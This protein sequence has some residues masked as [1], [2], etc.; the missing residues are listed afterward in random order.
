MSNEANRG[1]LRRRVGALAGLA[2]D[3]TLPSR[4]AARRDALHT[5]TGVDQPTDTPSGEQLNGREYADWF[6]SPVMVL[7]ETPQVIDSFVDNNLKKK[8]DGAKQ[9]LFGGYADAVRTE[10]GYEPVI[11][12]GKGSITGA[13]L[14][15]IVPGK[16]KENT[17]DYGVVLNPVYIG[18]PTDRAREIM[19]EIKRVED[20]RRENNQIPLFLDV[21]AR[22]ELLHGLRD[23]LPQVVFPYLQTV[24]GKALDDV[25][26]SDQAKNN[27]VNVVFVDDETEEIAN[28]P[29]HWQQAWG[30]FEMGKYG[31][32]KSV[33]VRYRETDDG[34]EYA[35]PMLH[36]LE[37]GHIALSPEDMV[38]QLGVYGSALE[39]GGSD[40]R[41]DIPEIP[42]DAWENSAGVKGLKRLGKFLGKHRLI[43][44]GIEVDDLVS[45][46]D[47]SNRLL[48][49][50]SKVRER[51][52]IARDLRKKAAG[53]ANQQEG[54][55]EVF[56]PELM[57]YLVSVT[58]KWGA[59]KT[60]L[61]SNDIVA[62][63]PNPADPTRVFIIR[64]EGIEPKGPSVEAR[65]FVGPIDEFATSTAEKYKDLK[66]VAKRVEGGYKYLEEGEIVEEK[67]LRELRA[68]MGVVH[69]HRDYDELHLPTGDEVIEVTLEDD[70][71][72]GCGVDLMEEKSRMA[73]EKAARL[74][75]EGGRKAKFAVFKVA[76]HGVNI[77]TF[78][79]PGEDGVIPDYAFQ[80]FE[81][82]VEREHDN[83]RLLHTVRQEKR[84]VEIFKDEQLAA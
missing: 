2:L 60:D 73:M 23:Q 81:E 3:R 69:M 27:F 21:E 62:V 43:S 52:E 65:E 70:M 74:W 13:L 18:K 58:G 68:I 61:T 24:G 76:R 5:S 79:T 9:T 78:P 30:W 35:T 82:M 19:R 8:L 44:P 14:H 37:G 7:V 33:T 67:D 55:Y 50:V 40:V 56:D 57:Q 20:E 36:T 41:E 11:W 1:P 22:K 83:L 54:A 28:L 63:I 26:L 42:R 17:T 72:V 64:V 53:Y 51:N 77:F 38:K 29:F 15:E 16:E 75:I 80:H 84:P 31:S 45:R 12:H 59:V 39:T 25:G 6:R 32:F 10:L 4:R 49:I 71:V 47:D 46:D 48:K 34:V 66:I